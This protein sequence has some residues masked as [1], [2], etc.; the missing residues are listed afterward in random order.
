MIVDP[1]CQSQFLSS[2]E[3]QNLEFLEPQEPSKRMPN[4]LQIKHNPKL[5]G[6]STLTV[7]FNSQLIKKVVNYPEKSTNPF[8]EK[9]TV[10]TNINPKPKQ[11][12]FKLLILNNNNKN[13]TNFVLEYGLNRIKHAS[14]REI[15][16]C[17][18]ALASVILKFL[19]ILKEKTIF[20]IFTTY[21]CN[22]SYIPL[23]NSFYNTIY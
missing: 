7:A 11:F 10:H 12:S 8:L 17:F 23:F 3:S 6:S 9:P 13:K 18:I 15:S 16:I 21:F 19:Q 20:S 22:I 1:F 14:S 2:L 4:Y 5:F